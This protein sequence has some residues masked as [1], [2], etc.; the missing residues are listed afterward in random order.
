MRRYRDIVSAFAPDYFGLATNY[1]VRTEHGVGV[2]VLESSRTKENS[3]SPER[4]FIESWW[5]PKPLFLVYQRPARGEVINFSPHDPLCTL[6]PLLAH[7]TRPHAM[8]PSERA[9]LEADRRAYEERERDPSLRWSSLE[10]YSFTRAYSQSARERRR[11]SSRS[12]IS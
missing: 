1:T 3:S 9:E 2:L 11:G 8:E 4:G 7:P 10:G 5:Y 6:V 12:P